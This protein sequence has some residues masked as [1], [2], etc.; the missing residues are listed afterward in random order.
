MASKE[1]ADNW[2]KTD[3]VQ[4][5]T[6]VEELEFRHVIHAMPNIILFTAPLF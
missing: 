2:K 1:Y 3:R 5:N 4:F 6:I